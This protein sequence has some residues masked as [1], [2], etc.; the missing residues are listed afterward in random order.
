MKLYSEKKLFEYLNGKRVIIVGPAPEEGYVDGFGD[1]IDSFD[2]V[3]RVNRGWRMS[4]ENPEVFG[5]KTNIL[6]HCLDFDEENGGFI[7]YEFLKKSK[8]ET[9]VS[10]YP[11]INGANY[12]DIMFKMGLRQ[13]CF[14]LFLK[15]N[16]GIDYSFVSDDFYLN[17]D[18]KM[19]T[20][21]NS[22]T[23][24]FLHLLQSNLSHLE[25]V[26]FSFFSKGY[27]PSYRSSIDGI[28]TKDAEHSESLVLNRMDKA[29]NHDLKK[30]ID[31][32]KPLL[33]NNSKVSFSRLMK[34][35]FNE[36]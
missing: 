8:C 20:R 24:A 36:K 10:C 21:P 4:K 34:E 5:S 27:V 11:N 6:Y 29:K 32:C 25:I 7:D 17:L 30:Q 2:I 16:G 3:V 26:G 14:N 19:N 15:Q 22:G 13:Y 33:I 31:F 12:R 9:I 23:V 18:S 28:T 35:V 1:F